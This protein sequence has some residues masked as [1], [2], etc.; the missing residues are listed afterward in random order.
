MEQLKINFEKSEKL[1][2]WQDRIDLYFGLSEVAAWELHVLEVKQ[3]F[4]FGSAPELEVKYVENRLLIA[5]GLTLVAA[6]AGTRG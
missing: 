4:A 2:Y 6:D 1:A 3:R 5:S